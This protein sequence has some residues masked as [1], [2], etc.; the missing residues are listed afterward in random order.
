M[1]ES[2]RVEMEAW[3]KRLEMKYIQLALEVA[4]YEEDREVGSDHDNYIEMD[5]I[6]NDIER[7]REG[8]ALCRK[9]YGED[10]R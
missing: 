3:L 10:S 4:A 1:P 7:A 2:S 5:R 8:V 9:H 6:E